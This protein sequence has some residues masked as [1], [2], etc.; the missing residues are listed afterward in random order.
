VLENYKVYTQQEIEEM[1][2]KYYS[3]TDTEPQKNEQ[4]GILRKTSG[5]VP[6]GNDLRMQTHFSM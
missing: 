5:M 1:R 2:A 3:D 6:F 4:R